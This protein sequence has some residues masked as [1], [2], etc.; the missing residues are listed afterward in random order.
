[1][2]LQHERLPDAAAAAAAAAAAMRA[3]WRQRMAALEAL[4]ES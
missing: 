3:Y 1:V 2:T 4:L